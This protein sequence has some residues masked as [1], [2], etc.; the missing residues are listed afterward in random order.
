LTDEKL[1]EAVLGGDQAS[2]EVLVGRY[3]KNVAAVVIGMLGS[4]PEAEDVGQETFIRFY[5]SLDR[6]R[7]ECAV[8]T[9]LTRIAINLSLNELK[10]RKRRFGL[11]FHASD[12]KFDVR[13]REPD[14]HFTL[15]QEAVRTAVQKLRS[16]L[17]AVV[18]LRYIE[19]YSTRETADLLRVPLG[20]VLSRQARAK[21]QLKTI[22]GEWQ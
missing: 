9:Y 4:G 13:D 20:T 11:F 14:A 12:G 19:G 22:L 5:R 8:G 1:I 6:F 2:F 15:E 10:R 17:R 7:G 18:V 16:D 3:E 21:K